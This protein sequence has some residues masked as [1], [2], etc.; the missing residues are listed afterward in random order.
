VHLV[1]LYK[2][3]DTTLHSVPTIV[4]AVKLR[5][6]TI[7]TLEKKYILFMIRTK[8]KI[9]TGTSQ[10]RSALLRDSGIQASYPVGRLLSGRRSHPKTLFSLF[11]F[12]WLIKPTHRYR[13]T[14]SKL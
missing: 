2:D 10:N 12:I 8:R 6:F 7:C 3:N 9:F 13:F 1:I 11:L 4:G 5:D 14:L